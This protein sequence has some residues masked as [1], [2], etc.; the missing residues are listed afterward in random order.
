MAESAHGQKDPVERIQKWPSK[1][2]RNLML[3][4]FAVIQA[5]E[6]L[7]STELIINAGIKGGLNQYHRLKKSFLKLTEGVIEYDS[8]TDIW[9]IVDPV[10]SRHYKENQLTA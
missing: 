3:H 7:E 4:M 10:F 2:E 8:A 9:S 6:P 1:T 5:H